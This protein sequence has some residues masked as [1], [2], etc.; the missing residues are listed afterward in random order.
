[1]NFFKCAVYVLFSLSIANL[2]FN[3]YMYRQLK[4]D[5][6]VVVI[7]DPAIATFMNESRVRE[8]QIFQGILMTHHRI[9]LHEPGKQPLCPICEDMNKSNIKSIT[10]KASDR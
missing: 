8:T 2:A 4:G 7:P 5:P 3:S 10:V 1:M 9:G 6:D